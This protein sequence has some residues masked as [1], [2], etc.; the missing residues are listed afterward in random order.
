MRI[1]KTTNFSL[2]SLYCINI[3]FILI[4][5]YLIFFIDKIEQ[6]F[7]F[8]R[9]WSNYIVLSLPLSL[10][11]SHTQSLSFFLYFS[12]SLFCSLQNWFSFRFSCS[13]IYGNMKIKK[14]KKKEKNVRRIELNRCSSWTRLTNIYC[15]YT[16]TYQYI[17][18]STHEKRDGKNVQEC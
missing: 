5:F 15:A 4:S 14:V 13:E 8:Q 6:Q 3:V 12:N 10:S 16:S 2:S 11:R 9:I 7:S 1:T 17:R 18:I